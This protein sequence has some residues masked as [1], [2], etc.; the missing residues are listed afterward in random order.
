MVAVFA[1]FGTLT[2]QQFKQ[3]SVGLAIAV[4]LDATV[5]R[6]EPTAAHASRSRLARWPVPPSP[7]ATVR[8]HPVA[9]GR[10][11]AGH[12][13]VSDIREGTAVPTI[14]PPK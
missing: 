3:L 8:Q 14:P 9:G 7:C 4:L 13:R 12:T 1:V 2:L 6:V 11:G 5:V 10:R